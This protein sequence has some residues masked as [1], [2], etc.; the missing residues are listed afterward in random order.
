[1]VK[2]WVTKRDTPTKEWAEYEQLQRPCQK[3][4]WCSDMDG[5]DD[6]SNIAI[7]PADGGGEARRRSSKM[8][9]YHLV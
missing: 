2:T 7:K 3:R 6:N 4:L 1:M 5:D 9:S 8:L